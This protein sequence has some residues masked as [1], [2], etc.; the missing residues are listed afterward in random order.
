MKKFLVV[1]LA[2]VVLMLPTAALA[3]T[4]AVAEA[5]QDIAQAIRENPISLGELVEAQ[6][7]FWG[8]VFL[9]FLKSAKPN[10][11]FSEAT[12]PGLQITLYE[13]E[14]WNL[15]GGKVS[16]YPERELFDQPSFIGVEWKGIP[17]L[18]DWASM[19]EK[20]NLQVV[21]LENG[22]ALGAAYEFRK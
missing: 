16:K 15:I 14:S 6:I 12:Y 11:T 8:E 5:G 17:F 18:K 1:L 4:G 7:D 22:F 20:F 9:R 19:F 21:Y 2:L 10:V 3:Q 13:Q